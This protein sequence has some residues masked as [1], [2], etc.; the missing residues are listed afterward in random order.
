MAE[1]DIASVLN[2]ILDDYASR[3]LSTLVPCFMMENEEIG[4]FLDES[5]VVDSY[6]DALVF[7]ESVVETEATFHVQDWTIQYDFVKDLWI[8]TKKLDFKRI[9]VDSHNR[10]QIVKQQLV[11][12]IA[13]LG[14]REFEKLL[15]YLFESIPDVENIFVQPQSHDGGFEFAA[16]FTDVLTR[17]PEWLLIQAKQQKHA[18][19]VAQVRELIGTLSVESNKHRGRKYRGVMISSKTASLKAKEAARDAI[20]SIDFLTHDDI[21]ELMIKNNL[22][23]SNEVLEFWALDDRF[24][25]ELEV[26]VE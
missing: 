3:G 5:D 11:R 17:T 9:V 7:L 10:K 20:Q 6:I 21:A 12:R 24:W 13:N 25:D 8:F 26:D 1:I 2:Q 18:V 14:P 19:S 23:W 22:G 4:V 16:V 15:I